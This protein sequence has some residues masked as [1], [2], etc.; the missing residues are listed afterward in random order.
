MTRGILQ[1]L[2]FFVFWPVKRLFIKQ[3]SPASAGL[4]PLLHCHGYFFDQK[5]RAKLRTLSQSVNSRSLLVSVLPPVIF[6]IS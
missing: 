6:M 3:K 2:A 4:K 5:S 1:K